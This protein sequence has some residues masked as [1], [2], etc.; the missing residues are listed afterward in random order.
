[1]NY[2]NIKTGFKYSLI[3]SLTI[4]LCAASCTSE[5]PDN[6]A[7]PAVML[8]DFHLSKWTSAVYSADINGDGMEEILA[9]SLD[10]YTYIFDH[11]GK[12]AGKLNTGIPLKF[13]VDDLDA[14]GNNEIVVGSADYFIYVYNSNFTLQWKHEVDII[15]SMEITDINGDGNKEILVGV[16]SVSDHSNH[17]YAIRKHIEP[18]GLRKTGEFVCHFTEDVMGNVNDIEI[19]DLDNDGK[20]DILLGTGVWAYEFVAGAKYKNQVYVLDQGCKR[21]E[22]RT[23]TGPVSAT[24]IIDGADKVIVVGTHSTVFKAYPFIYAYK[25]SRDKGFIRFWEKNI[26]GDTK[27]II[28]RDIDND[29]AD[30]I[31]I[32]ANADMVEGRSGLFILDRDGE[33]KA[34]SSDYNFNTIFVEDINSDGSL[35]IIGSMDGAGLYVLDSSLN[36]LWQYDEPGKSYAHVSDID[37]DNIPEIIFGSGD[38]YVFK[39]KEKLNIPGLLNEARILYEQAMDFYENGDYD[40]AETYFENAGEK[41]REIK[42]HDAGAEDMI[43]ECDTRLAQIAVEREGEE[44]IEK[45]RED[46]DEHYGIALDYYDEG[47]YESAKEHAASARELYEKLNDSEGIE[48]CSDLIMQIEDESTPYTEDIES[49]ENKTNY[50]LL[51]FGFIIFIIIIFAI[52]AAILIFFFIIK[53]K[54]GGGEDDGS[55]GENE[56]DKKS[57][58]ETAGDD[59][60][61]EGSEEEASGK[62]SD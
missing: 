38:L 4:F 36:V 9:G 43:R 28:I 12:F 21:K 11:K 40:N 3:I 1:M 37:S 57:D 58:E 16:E 22:I 6:A 50:T 56:G 17:F 54:K 52:L 15:H 46:A 48:K 5:A 25:Y 24:G 18:T 42:K 19:Y 30:D 20:I 10:G 47:D 8:W 33:I 23:I 53:K 60:V 39:F 51:I 27:D 32:S 45:M 2:N 7:E 26:E 62:E 44:E 55:V 34:S 59:V 14:D 61:K 35:E 29:G 31:I 13:I 41:Y 49:E